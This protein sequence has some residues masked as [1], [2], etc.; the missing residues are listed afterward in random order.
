MKNLI[1]LQISKHAHSKKMQQHLSYSQLY[2][3]EYWYLLFKDLKVKLQDVQEGFYKKGKAD[4]VEQVKNLMQD[5]QGA[6]FIV[7]PVDDKGKKAS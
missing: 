1:Q 3:E 6:Y 4:V 7:Q 2:E 5:P